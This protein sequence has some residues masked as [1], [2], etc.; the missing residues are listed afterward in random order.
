VPTAPYTLE[1]AEEDIA[2]LRGQLDG[3]LEAHVLQSV[4]TTPNADPAGVVLH[5]SGGQPNFINPAGL[6]MG[7][8]GAQNAFFANN[9]VTSVALNNLAQGTIPA[10]DAEIGAV[11]EVD[12]WGNGTW[13]ATAQ[14]LTLAVFLGGTQMATVQIGATFMNVSLIF[15]WRAVVRTICVTTGVTGTWQSLIFGNISLF[16][17]TLLASGSS[18]NNPTNSFVSCE[19]TA[20]TTKDTTA[21]NSIGL[22]AG[23]NATTGAPTITC[24]VA[25]FKRLA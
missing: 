14:V 4:N 3:V 7:V 6:T 12:A 24:Q 20:T 17:G 2:D 11:Y 13:G 19:S 5:A 1:Q 10:N 21:Q 9:T 25:M 15:R 16:S 8:V 23:W 18:S 22:S